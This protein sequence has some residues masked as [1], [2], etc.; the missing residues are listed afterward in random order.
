[1]SFQVAGMQTIFS[2]NNENI[3]NFFP[4][5]FPVPFRGQ[6]VECQGS[7]AAEREVFDASEAGSALVMMSEPQR[8][9]FIG[10]RSR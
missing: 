3:R 9:V 4:E 6:S 1:M 5:K 10:G 8:R 7:A 2:I